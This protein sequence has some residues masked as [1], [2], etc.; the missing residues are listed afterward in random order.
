MLQKIT[1][2]TSSGFEL[3]EADLEPGVLLLVRVQLALPLLDVGSGLLQGRSQA[4]VIV[5]ESRQLDF[6]FFRIC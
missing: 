4:G 6:P 1:A 2:F 3:D 5:L